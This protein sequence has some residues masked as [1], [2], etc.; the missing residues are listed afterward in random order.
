MTVLLCWNIQCCRGVDGKTDPARIAQVLRGMG[1]ADVICLQEVARFDP[2]ID[3]GRDQAGALAEAF[4]G[5]EPVFG[6]AIDR[7]GGSGGR[8]KAFGNM[9]LSRLPV[10][11]VF[12]HPLPQPPEPGIR[13]MPRQAVEVVV[14]GGAGPLRVITTHLEFHSLAQRLAQVERLRFL[15]QE[16]GANQRAPGADVGGTYALWPRPAELV[17]CGDFNALPDSPDHAAMT[18]PFADGTPGLLDAWRLAFPGREHAPTAGIFDADQWPQ[19][20]HCRDFFFLSEPLAGR[21]EK[22]WV[23]EETDASDHQPLRLDLRG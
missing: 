23:N 17:V 20:P 2:E 1:E 16:A 19:G 8:R 7:S 21:V 10:L 18:A 3:D 14:E 13:H 6:A 9:I 15:H 11:Q 5:Y 12:H 22:V 4:P